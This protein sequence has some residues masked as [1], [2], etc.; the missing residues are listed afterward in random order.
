MQWNAIIPDT[1]ALDA[2]AVRALI[3]DYPAGELQ[4]ID[5]RQSHAFEEQRLPGA[6]NIPLSELLA[7]AH[8][9]DKDKPTLV[10]CSIGGRSKAAVRRLLAQGFGDVCY[11]KH[12]MRGWKGQIAAG[13]PE[14]S[15]Q[16]VPPHAH[17]RDV[18]QLAFAV[19]NG[20]RL[21]YERFA[22]AEKDP[23]CK[24]LY[25]TLAREEGK[26]GEQLAE[27]YPQDLGTTAMEQ[28]NEIILEGGEPLKEFGKHTYIYLDSRREI[29]AF[30]MALEAQA[31]DL[32]LRLA[33]RAEERQTRALCLEMAD[34]EKRHMGYLLSEMD[35]L[36]ESDVQTTGA[37]H[38]GEG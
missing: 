24:S 16:I 25:L 38:P 30:S 21:L 19:E 17:Y 23:L 31:M 10:Y 11:L 29:L 20:M 15:L 37:I 13:D 8:G 7:G 28:Q 4:I 33:E 34:E 2:G 27:K 26:H 5:V 18:L 35:R 9:L 36:V 12:G 14:V 6:V 1:R 22:N 32:Y 3:D